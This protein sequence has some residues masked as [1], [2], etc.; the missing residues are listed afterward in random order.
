MIIFDMGCD[1]MTLPE[2]T[3][4]ISALK[5]A[6]EISKSII[7]YSKDITINEKSIELHSVI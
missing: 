1:D 7:S 4:A 5:A 6:L 3:T 2:I